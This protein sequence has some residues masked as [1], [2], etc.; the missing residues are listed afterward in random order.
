MVY[1]YQNPRASAVDIRYTHTMFS[2]TSGVTV[3]APT[4]HLTAARCSLL[5]LALSVLTAAI[6]GSALASCSPG[7]NSGNRSSAAETADIAPSGGA[8]ASADPADRPQMVAFVNVSVIP[9]DSE[10]VLP[11]HTVLIKGDRIE[12]LGPAMSVDIPTG[13]RRI[14]GAGKYLL[15]GLAEMHGH[16][17]RMS[18]PRQAIEDV[19]FLYVANGI[20]TVRGMLGDN[21]Q[22][23]L[24]EQANAGQIIAPTLYLAGPSFNGGSVDSPEQAVEMVRAQK[25]EGWNLLKVH[26]GLTR[27]EYDAMA[28]TANDLGIRFGGHVPADVGLLHALEMNQETF[29]HVDGYIEYIFDEQTGQL[30]ETRLAEAVEKTKRADAWIVPT[31]VLWETLLGVAELDMLKAY[32]ELRY[33]EPQRV[34]NWIQRHEQRLAN[35]QLDPAL[36][37]S[38]AAGRIRILRALHKAGVKILMGTDAPQQFSVPGFS[39]HREL[40]RM[41]D[42][43][44]SAH[45]VL[46][47]GTANV[48]KYFSNEDAF[49][50]IAAGKRADVLLVEGNPLDDLSNLDKLA[51]VMVRGQWLDKSDIRAR[52]DA[53]AARYA[54]EDQRQ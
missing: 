50:V 52:L 13:A 42:A 6:A 9:M 49:G 3:S 2:H 54:T 51:G 10:R 21:G 33:V 8:N 18:E 47:S 22:I 11:A 37:K 12:H 4:R 23:A 34:K 15:P 1:W 46:E 28:R 32:P 14:D 7:Q 31:M 44:M 39:L 43:G 53:I 30:D 24:R 29:D 36:A 20:T 48:G 40:R 26:P 41:T 35:P 25:R 17:P 38:L 16:I 45:A 19:L 5:T 27:A